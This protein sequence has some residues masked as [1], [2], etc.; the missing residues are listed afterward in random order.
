MNITDI[1]ECNV[2]SP[3]CDQMCTNTPGSYVCSCYAGYTMATDGR[4]NGKNIFVCQAADHSS[5]HAADINECL[6]ANNC[7]QICL[8]TAG[9]YY[10]ECTN[11]FVLDSNGHSCKGGC[12]CNHATY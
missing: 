3:P 6:G 4:C 1:D 11:G 8:N 2:T 12:I 9:S 5:L 10:C 7:Q